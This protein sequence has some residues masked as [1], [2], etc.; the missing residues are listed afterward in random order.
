MLTNIMH[1]V[2]FYYYKL[3]NRKYTYVVTFIDISVTILT[4]ITTLKFKTSMYTCIPHN[5]QTT[6]ITD[7]DSVDD[8][9]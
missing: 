9:L 3:V 7:W 6:S 8:I 5:F 1:G 2:S 4:W